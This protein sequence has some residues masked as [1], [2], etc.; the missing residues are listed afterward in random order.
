MTEPA[1]LHFCCGPCE[2]LCYGYE[3]EACFPPSRSPKIARILLIMNCIPFTAGWGTMWS[4]SQV[5]SRKVKKKGK[6]IAIGLLQ[7]LLAFVI[8]GWIWSIVHGLAL[9]E[10]ALLEHSIYKLR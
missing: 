10:N 9:Y 5:C 1:D 7:F 2:C 3:D 6:I 8:Y 4:S